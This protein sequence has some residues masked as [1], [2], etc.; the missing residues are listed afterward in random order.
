MTPETRNSI[1]FPKLPILFIVMIC[2]GIMACNS[3]GGDKG[4]KPPDNVVVK[5]PE[6]ADAKASELLEKLLQ[7]TDENKGK[8]NDSIR[9]NQWLLLKKIYSE[10]QYQPLWSEKEH[11]NPI[12]DSLYRF[13][14]SCKAYGLFPSDYYLPTLATIFNGLISDTIHKR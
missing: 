5:K 12:A 4:Q 3:G 1:I 9:L 13:I 10:R 7:Y 6:Q 14:D 2:Y 11:W 8:L